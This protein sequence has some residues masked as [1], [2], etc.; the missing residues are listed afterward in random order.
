MTKR[1]L[2]VIAVALL[3]LGALTASVRAQEDPL[4]SPKLR[5]EWADFKKQYDAKKIVVI[6]VRDIGSYEAGHIPGALTVPLD[7]VE[8]RLGELKKLKKPI[9]LYC[10]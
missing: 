6:D 7:Q 1:M 4:A 3:A 2:P 10:A 8:A 5:I 9:V